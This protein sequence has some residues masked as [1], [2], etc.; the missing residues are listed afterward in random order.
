MKVI[1]KIQEGQK[2]NT[3][4]KYIELDDTTFLQPLWRFIRGD[5]RISMETHIHD[6]INAS[7]NL[8]QRAVIDI[9]NKDNKPK[10]IYLNRTPINFLLYFENVLEDFEKGIKN[11]RDTYIQDN[12]LSSKLEIEINNIINQKYEISEI[13]KKNI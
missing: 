9:E 10:G 5:S 11:L 8:I 1:G 3:K 13:K 2:I 6:T 4:N 12:T 7:N